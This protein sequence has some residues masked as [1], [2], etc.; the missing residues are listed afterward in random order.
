MANLMDLLQGQLD[1][2]L[3]GQL[4]NQLGGVDRQKTTVAAQGVMTTLVTA[5]AKNAAHPEKA[6]GLEKALDNDHDGSILDNLTDLLGGNAQPQ[7]ARAMNGAGIIKHLLGGQQSG[8]VDMIS[9][10]SGLNSGQTGNLMATLA[11]IVMGMLGK[12][13]RQ[14]GLDIGGIANML[15]GTVNQQRSSGNPLMDMANRFL[16]QDGDGSA[17]DDVAGMVGKGLLGKLFGGR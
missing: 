8:A 2:N 13:K 4:S 12:Q 1:D 7:N 5:L 11:P 6:A 14:Q 10:M 17:L 15:S 16:D 9:Q 3:I